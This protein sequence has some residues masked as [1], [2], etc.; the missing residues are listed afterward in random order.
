M[1]I[2]PIDIARGPLNSEKPHLPHQEEA[3]EALNRYFVLGQKSPQN[4][5]LVLPTGGGKTYTAVTWLLDRAIPNGYRVLWLSHR[6]ELVGTAYRMFVDLSPLLG[7]HGIKKL[8]IASISEEHFKMFNAFR[9]DVNICSIDTA[10][11]KNGLKYLE[12]ILGKTGKD[13]LVVVIEEAHH[14]VM[15]SYTKVL[16]E[17]TN[18]SPNR[19]LLGLTATPKRMQMAEYKK[20][21]TMFSVSD[22]LQENRGNENGYIY[23]AGYNRLMLEGFL[24]RPVYRKVDTQIQGD[25]AFTVTDEDVSYFLRWGELSESVKDQL[26]KSSN[27]NDI[28]VDEY[29]NNANKYGKTLVFAVNQLHCKT[30]YKAFTRAGISCNYCV[31]GEP[32]TA[33]VIRDF[34]AGAFDVLINVL[35]EAVSIND[36]QS[37]FLTGQTNSDSL[38]IQK[39][40]RGLRGVASGGTE[41]AYIVEFQDRWNRFSFWNDPTTLDFDPEIDVVRTAD[42][43]APKQELRLSSQSDAAC[44]WEVLIRIRSALHAVLQG[45][46]RKS[47]FPCGWYAILDAEGGDRKVMVFDN[48]LPGYEAIAQ[49]AAAIAAENLNADECRAKYFDI[50]EDLP[51][52]DDLQLVLNALAENG[53]MPEYYTFDMRDKVDA[54]AISASFRRMDRSSSQMEYRLE[55]TFERTP[56]LKELYGDYDAFKR[57]I[58]MEL[59]KPQTS[60]EAAVLTVG[61]LEH[62]IL[63]GHYDLNALLSE[64]VAESRVLDPHLRPPIRWTHR[65]MKSY[66][67]R[68]RWFDA[69]QCD[70]LINCLLSSPQVPKD[71]VEYVIFRQLLLANG[72]KEGEWSYPAADQHDAFLTNLG[73]RFKMEDEIW[74]VRSGKKQ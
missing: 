30:L 26:A 44:N 50:S 36:V 66:F 6:P 53:E 67:G 65:P 12:R 5:L 1:K 29:V 54:R 41:Y 43:E 31:P 8:R 42:G 7:R 60:G 52:V 9:Y 10:A 51:D 39:V 64:T 59:D 56:M 22:N 55:K 33:S 72:I 70:I 34:K 25:E 27:R 57:C 23:E 68:C 35:D 17:I 49:N 40:G 19:I 15:P 71:V 74:G 4:G 21:R 69:K 16:K 37:V 45:E 32:G 14:A 58:L 3:L 28:I 11:S 73:T 46:S 63:P 18:I 62:K 61:E 47:A 24:A 2:S 13:K 38:L 20:L 48:Q